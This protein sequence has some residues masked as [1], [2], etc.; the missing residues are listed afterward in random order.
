MSTTLPPSKT[1]Q[2]ALKAARKRD[3]PRPA[4]S[5][6]PPSLGAGRSAAPVQA[7]RNAQ[8]RERRIED[9]GASLEKNQGKAR[10]SF[11]RDIIR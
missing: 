4:P 5:P 2:E 9:I 8:M 10:R 1:E 11:N 6:A 7:R 3:L